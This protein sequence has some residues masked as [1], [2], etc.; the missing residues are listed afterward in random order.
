MFTPSLDHDSSVDRYAAEIYSLD[1]WALVWSRD[2]G[3]PAVVSGQCN[4]DLTQWIA[5]LPAGQYQIVV[6]AVDDS[7]TAQS[8][9]ATF[10]FVR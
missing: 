7:T 9:G 10:N 5:A 3:R 1:K 4:V 8:E 6:R 2:L